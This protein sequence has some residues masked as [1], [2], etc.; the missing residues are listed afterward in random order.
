M[1][2]LIY[3][4]LLSF[5]EMNIATGQFPDILN[6]GRE[7]GSTDHYPG[8]D[9]TS[10]GRLTVDVCCKEPAG[11]TSIAVTVQGS[12]DGSTGWTDVGKSV[13]NLELM[14]AGPCQTTVS[15]N[16]FKYLRVSIAADGTFTGTAKAYLNTYAGK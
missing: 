7:D 12:E 3:D 11:G 6:L 13:S 2:N 8:K 16:K 5:G 14:K 15:P 1:A 9:F 4:E 10:A